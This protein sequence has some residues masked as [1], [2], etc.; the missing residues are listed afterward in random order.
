MVYDDA[1]KPGTVLVTNPLAEPRRVKLALLSVFPESLSTGDK[2]E[3]MMWIILRC[4]RDVAE[5]NG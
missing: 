2:D 1:G 5:V 4:E 3:S